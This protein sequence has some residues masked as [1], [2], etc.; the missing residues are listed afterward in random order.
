[1]KFNCLHC[2]TEKV[3]K[4]STRTDVNKYCNN[5]CQGNYQFFN[6]T[7]PKFYRGEISNRPTLKRVLVHLFGDKCAECGSPPLHNDKPL[8]MQVDHKD[9]NAGND[10]PDNVQLLCPNCHTQTPTFGAKNKG[11]GRGSRS[12]PR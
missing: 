5:I 12:L 4:K 8:S 6:I 2:G 11:N 7:L 9:G 3:V 10:M 1:M